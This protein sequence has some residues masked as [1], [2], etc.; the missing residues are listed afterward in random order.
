MATWSN[1]KSTAAFSPKPARNSG[2]FSG[3]K[4]GKQKMD[5]A[6]MKNSGTSAALAEAYKTGHKKSL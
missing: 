3:G 4:G 6:P 2:I 1:P 5:K